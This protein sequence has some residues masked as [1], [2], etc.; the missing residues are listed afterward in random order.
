MR[1]AYGGV[2]GGVDALPERDEVL[3]KPRTGSELSVPEILSVTC[4]FKRSSECRRD[5][6]APLCCAV[7]YSV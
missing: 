4:S 2:D 5:C 3:K 7:N 1:E 6:C